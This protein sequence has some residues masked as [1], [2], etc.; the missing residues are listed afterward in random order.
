MTTVK[1]FKVYVS[2]VSPS[3][4]RITVA[5]GQRSNRKLKD[6]KRWPIYAINS[7]DNA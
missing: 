1:S 2:S 3:S 4:E 7:V 5:K 6:S